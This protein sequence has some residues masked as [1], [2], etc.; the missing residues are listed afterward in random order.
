M[1]NRRSNNKNRLLYDPNQ[2]N[3]RRLG[4]FSNTQNYDEP[5]E[6]ENINEE[7]P[8]KASQAM[9]AAEELGKEQA[10]EQVK[11]M[12]NQAGKQ[13]AASGK[14]AVSALGK[15]LVAFIAANPWVLLVL[16]GVILILF[17]ILSVASAPDDEYYQKMC[18]FYSASVELKSGITGEKKQLSMED[19]II[20][21]TYALTSAGS[22]SDDVIKA[23][24]IVLK[25]NGLAY[26]DYNDN[27]RVLTVT[28]TVYIYD[29][30]VP[31]DVKSNY[32]SLY[33]SISSY[34]YVPAAYEE[35]IFGM[36]GS[37]AL[38][39]NE[40]IIKEMSA[41]SM[42]YSQ[43]LKEI[44][45]GD[46][47]ETSSDVAGTLYVGDSRLQ[48]MVLAGVVSESDAVY[49]VG[50]GYNWFVGRGSFSS[51]YTNS[52][53]GGIS[54][55]NSKIAASNK[56]NIVSWLGVNDLKSVSAN[57]Y[58]SKYYELAT[59]DWS[60]HN[61]Y[62]VNVGPVSDNASSSVTNSDIDNFNTSLG[63][64][65]AS[66]GLK[67][68][69]FIEVSYDISSY[70]SAGLH[71]SW[72]DYHNIFASIQSYIDISGQ[73]LLMDLSAFCKQDDIT[74]NAFWWPIGSAAPTSGDIYG[75]TPIYSVITST[76][77]PRSIN[78]SN[79][80]HGA[81]DIGGI[82][83]NEGTV[84]ATKSGTVTAV[85]NTCDNNGYYRNSCGGGL[86]NYV[87]IEHSDG[88][89]SKYGHLYPNS[90]S[91]SV[92]QTV[93]QGQKIGMVGNSGS[94]TGCH[95]HFEIWENG[96]KVDPLNYVDID[97]PR[98]VTEGGIQNVC[99]ALVASGYSNNAVA[100][101]MVNINAESGFRTTAVEY[102]SGHTIDDIF[103]VS[104]YEAA[105]FGLVQWSFGR[106]VSMISYARY[107]GLSPVSLQA[108]IEYLNLE[109]QN[110]YPTTRNA[111]YG[112]GSAYSMGVTFCTNFE[113]P[114]QYQTTC[115]NRVSAGINTFLNYVNNGC[116]D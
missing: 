11:T 17:I 12:A 34:I 113:V 66:S 36:T 86:G 76:F 68:L 42:S 10:K 55:I 77:G 54:G 85:S 63:D 23:V 92:G 106:R 87:V 7:E 38:K 109:I 82:T 105:G 30:N 111:L 110:N 44:Y 75:G 83:C 51:K 5:I 114:Y 43:T 26:G 58:Y 100:A 31:D 27:T 20:G 74:N 22:Y 50:Y 79:S 108:Q 35:N 90:I 32:S 3:I 41:L 89:L 101:M 14:A 40:S 56:Y 9:D 103:D 49:G 33:S 48:G 19:Y 69:N 78:G 70:D 80:N 88:I 52:V 98:P 116:S 53:Y 72:K 2:A 112:S 46:E 60:D 59:G 107:K 24:M 8:S 21:T 1:I 62:V 18:N 91:V 115:P 84:I 37:S 61:I 65:I 64:L 16:G 99:N 94:S 6:D 39:L 57:K 81:I 104:S 93:K 97:N 13:V 25:T 95:L 96:V 47:E 45:G 71:Y 29:E 73:Y 15:K 67:N 4:A 28:D 102:A